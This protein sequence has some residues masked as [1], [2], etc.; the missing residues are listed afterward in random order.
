MVGRR[1]RLTLHDFKWDYDWAADGRRRPA[2]SG[3]RTACSSSPSWTPRST[4]PRRW[5][6]ENQCVESIT[7]SED[8]LCAA[9]RF[10]ENFAGWMTML[11]EI[12][13]SSPRPTGVRC[14][15]EIATR[16]VGRA[17][18]PSSRSRRAVRSRSSPP[19]AT[20]STTRRTSTGRPIAA[21]TSTSCGCA[22]SA[23]RTA[24]FTAFLN[25]EIDLTLNTTLG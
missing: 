1:R 20:A 12:R 15:E 9:I 22:S 10:Q 21:R 6:P 5:A 11:T 18:T 16:A 19:A 14:P 13:R 7:V 8:G 24:M 3:A 4:W 23:R 17:A 2:P 25:G